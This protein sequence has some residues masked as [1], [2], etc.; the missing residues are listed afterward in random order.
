MY[1]VSRHDFLN[2][3]CLACIARSDLQ[4]RSPI[5]AAARR[6][7]LTEDELVP[8]VEAGEPLP[9]AL[10]SEATGLS[11][12]DRES[13]ATV[14]GR[15]VLEHLCGTVRASGAGVA[16]SAP[17]LSA[18]PGVLLAAD[19]VRLRLGHPFRSSITMASV[20]RGPHD[21]W[22]FT[23]RKFSGCVCTDDVYRTHFIDK[24]AGGA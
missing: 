24:W 21:R 3:A 5:A 7:G 17:M 23:R 9:D 16:V 22:T 14:P 2:D 13:L 11:D 8:Y 4:D 10:L 1:I 20:L 12:A 15:N 18:A 19:F 6:L